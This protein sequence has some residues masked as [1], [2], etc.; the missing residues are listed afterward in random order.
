MRSK[1][2]DVDPTKRISRL[3]SFIIMDEADGVHEYTRTTQMAADT[4]EL[5][6]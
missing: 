4:T 6:F 5:S 2:E 1:T 3:G